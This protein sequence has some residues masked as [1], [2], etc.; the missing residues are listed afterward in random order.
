MLEIL[1]YKATPDSD[2]VLAA[3]YYHFLQDRVEEGIRF[4]EKIDRQAIDEKLQYDYL[5]SYVAFYKGDVA[6][7]KKLASKYADYPVERWRKR[8]ASVSAQVKEIEQG[9]AP[10]V[11]DE[12]NR[13]QKIE[14]LAATEP[15]FDFEVEKGE[16][17]INYRN[18]KDARVNFYPM[19]VELLF[20]RRPF[21][22]EASEQ[23]TFV[24]PNGSLEVKLPAG[25][26]HVF[27]LPAKYREGNVMIE[28]EAGG[29]R[30]SKTYYA[31]RLQVEMT[32]SYGRVRVTEDKT[33]KPLSSTYVKVYARM[34]DGRVKFYKDGYTD[35]RGK[36][37]Y[38]SLN[39]GQLDDVDRFAV[40]VLDDQ[41]G[42]MIREA[43]P[44]KQ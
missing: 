33:A 32:E 26:N 36:F 34:N 38:A 1:K 25:E 17:T 15:A 40:L 2:D 11:I 5:A 22:S 37:D 44:P 20:S 10:E 9:D 3:T 24:Q 21:V 35:F 41:A 42:A 28:I 31:N 39:T 27:A 12:E 29:V 18:L 8:F 7:A 6:G 30:K 43:K 14:N 16:V 13:E 4:F 19:E 23:F